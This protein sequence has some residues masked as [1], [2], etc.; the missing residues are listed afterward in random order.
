ML[1]LSCAKSHVSRIEPIRCDCIG[2]I[3]VCLTDVKGTLTNRERPIICGH[4]RVQ[5]SEL[6]TTL[7]CIP[8]GQEQIGLC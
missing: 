4:H 8:L 1:N 5:E 6:K 3:L 2:Q 7:Y